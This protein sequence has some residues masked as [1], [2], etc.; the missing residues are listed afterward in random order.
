MDPYVGRALS[1]VVSVLGAVLAGVGIL[2]TIGKNRAGPVVCGLVGVFLTLMGIFGLWYS[3]SQI[4]RV[5]PFREVIHAAS[6]AV[7]V[8]LE[9]PRL[10]GTKYLDEGAVVVFAGD[11][12]PLLFLSCD[13]CRIRNW[14]DSTVFKAEVTL[15]PGSKIARMCLDSLGRETDRIQIGIDLLRG[16]PTRVISGVI[17]CTFNDHVQ[18]V[19]SIPSQE[20]PDGKITIRDLTEGFSHFR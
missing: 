18:T 6:A 12:R 5:A 19:F 9:S 14:P 4:E 13:E 10:E 8:S 16:R 20:S 15:E 2:L 17:I 3:G 1:Y 11:S 7:R